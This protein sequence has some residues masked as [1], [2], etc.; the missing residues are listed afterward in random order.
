MLPSSVSIQRAGCSALRKLQYRDKYIYAVLFTEHHPYVSVVDKK[1]LKHKLRLQVAVR[2]YI[3]SL[4]E[5]Q[6]GCKAADS[7]IN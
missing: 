1:H 4:V 7:C 5:T 6:L 3:E 2:L